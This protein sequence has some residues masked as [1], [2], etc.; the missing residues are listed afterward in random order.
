YA[1]AGHGPDRV[2]GL[3]LVAA[4]P[5]HA[6]VAHEAAVVVP[7]LDRA[8]AGGLTVGVRDEAARRLRPGMAAGGLRAQARGALG[9]GERAQ[10]VARGE[11]VALALAG[12]RRAA[13][14][15][16]GLQVLEARGVG[17]EDRERRVR[18]R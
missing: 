18:R 8:P 15:E 4:L 1:E 10:R 12:A 11:L 13:W 7:R 17:R 3:V 14:P 9:G 2:V 16:H 5:R 6:V